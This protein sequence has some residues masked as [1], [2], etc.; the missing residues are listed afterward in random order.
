MDGGVALVYVGQDQGQGGEE[1]GGLRVGG[2]KETYR[3]LGEDGVCKSTTHDPLST[4]HL[5]SFIIHR[6]SSL[7][8]HHSPPPPSEQPDPEHPILTTPLLRLG[9]PPPS[10]HLIILLRYPP[11]I[12]TMG[13]HRSICSD[14]VLHASRG[15]SCGGGWVWR[16]GWG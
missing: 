10:S 16:G 12:K 8:H 3:D 13:I 4:T 11:F 1:A 7:N 5:P 15:A 9:R 14:R 6:P 2:R